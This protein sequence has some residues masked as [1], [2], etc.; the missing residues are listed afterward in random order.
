[1]TDKIVYTASSTEAA[2]EARKIHR[3]MLELIKQSCPASV[4]E[5]GSGRGLL[6]AEIAASGIKYSGIEPDE[7]QFKACQ[8]NFPHLSV[9]RASCYENP[10]ELDLG[11]FD[12]VISNDVIEHLYYPRKLVSF[13]RSLVKPAGM[14]I[15][16]TPDFGS[17]WKNI[18]YSLTNKWDQV[19]SPLWEGGH[20][21]FFSKNSLEL[22]FKEGGF[23]NFSW[24]SVRNINYPIFRMSIIC[25]CSP[26]HI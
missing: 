26:T 5:I 24:E 2:P 7:E 15:T 1:M 11:Q 21:K 16:C 25:T 12:L 3:K 8:R 22:I 14:V 18:A 9:K 10:T 13:A 20:I 17:Y 6:G 4:F 19:H 23:G